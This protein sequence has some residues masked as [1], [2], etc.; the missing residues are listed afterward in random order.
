MFDQASQ[1]APARVSY[2]NRGYLGVETVVFNVD[3]DPSNPAIPKTILGAT[4]TTLAILGTVTVNGV[5]LTTVGDA[6]L[7][8]S[9]IVKT[10]TN[11][12]PGAQVLGSLATGLLKVTTTTGALSTLVAAVTTGTVT[13]FAAGVG[14]AVLVDSTFTGNSGIAAYTIGDIVLALKAAGILAA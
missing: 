4:G 2:L 8:G 11:A 6:G 13:G 9:Y 12:P 3:A 5:A 10:A 7:L 1:G 14:A